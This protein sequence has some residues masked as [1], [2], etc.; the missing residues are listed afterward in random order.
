MNAKN[1]ISR[2]A[3]NWN[4]IELQANIQP[5]FNTLAAQIDDNEI[6][7]LGGVDRDDKDLG[8]VLLYNTQSNQA[9][10]VVSQSS[11]KFWSGHNNCVMTRKGQ[12]LA[13]PHLY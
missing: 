11:I 2:I 5:R 9:Q 6:V 8:E 13:I 7:I 3:T 10:K 12:I 1:F 4:L